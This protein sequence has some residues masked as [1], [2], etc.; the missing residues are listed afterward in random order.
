MCLY[1]DLKTQ[2]YWRSRNQK[3]NLDVVKIYFWTKNC[4]TSKTMTIKAQDHIWIKLLRN[5]LSKK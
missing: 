2:A 3:T 1:K 4:L 5:Q